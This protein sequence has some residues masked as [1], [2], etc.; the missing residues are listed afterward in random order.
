MEKQS[1]EK[2]TK[3]TLTPEEINEFKKEF[4]NVYLLVVEGKK[5]YIHKPTRNIMDLAA[6]ASRTKDS[7]FNETILKNCW[8]AG[9]KELV[10]DDDYFFSA[11]KQLGS[12]IKYKEAELKE[13]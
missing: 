11:G 8:L 5:A 13:L 3:K 9:D 6:L 1:F 7:Q 10:E 2:N 12:I 4:G